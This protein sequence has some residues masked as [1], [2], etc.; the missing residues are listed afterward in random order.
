M[1][2]LGITL[3]YMGGVLKR[4]NKRKSSVK[5]ILNNPNFSSL[6]D[7]IV[8]DRRTGKLWILR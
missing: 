6:Q 4:G 2:D 8:V 5:S 7:N 3:T 1:M